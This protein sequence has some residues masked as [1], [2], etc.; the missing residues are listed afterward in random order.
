LIGLQSALATLRRGIGD[1]SRIQFN[2]IVREI[3]WRRGRADVHTD[4][5]GVVSGERV[6]VT[7]PL[8]VMKNTPGKR[9]ASLSFTPALPDKESAAALVEMGHATKMVLRFRS[10]FW[11]NNAQLRDVLFL[12]AF[13]QPFPTFWSPQ[14]PGLPL[15]TAWAGGA[16]S[17]RLGTTNG[18]ALLEMALSSLAAALHVTKA[19]VERELETHYYHDWSTD[20]FSAGAYTYVAPGGVDA[21]RRLAS[22]VDDTLF[23]AG[24]AT[25]GGGA[26]A[27]MEGAITSGRRAADELLSS[28]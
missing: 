6:I 2:T 5:A 16:Q 10:P 4:N 28:L 8:P 18:D 24:E 17:K 9:D 21:H 27:T 11:R 23:F 22:A 12:H 3:R 26:N 14:S 13:D 1:G 25:C 20:P 19:E 7:V 15:I